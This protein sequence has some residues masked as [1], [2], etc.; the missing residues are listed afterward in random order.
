MSST[1]A[2]PR[3]FL[4]RQDININNK[5]SPPSPHCVHVKLFFIAID[6]K[7]VNMSTIDLLPV[8]ILE[9][10]FLWIDL[11]DLSMCSRACRSWFYVASRLLWRQPAFTKDEQVQTLLHALTCD[12]DDDNLAANPC[13]LIRTLDFSRPLFP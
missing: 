4:R 2:I 9:L 6:F 8:E 1:N 11:K 12:T 13:G 7:H 3:K 5:R 10:V